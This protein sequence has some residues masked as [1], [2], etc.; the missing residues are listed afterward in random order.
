MSHLLLV[1]D[2]PN[3]LSSLRRAL[4][5][6]PDKIFCGE[7]SVEMYT[8]PADALARAKEKA[9]DLVISDY[10]MPEIDG[11]TFL[12][13]LGK[14]QP[15]IARIIVSGFADLA[16]LIEAI[17]RAQIFRFVSK[18]WDECDL[19]LAISQA[20]AHRELM[21]E[22]ARL[23]DELRAERGKL[24]RAEL[25]LKRLEAENPGLAYVRRSPD[26]GIELDPDELK[27]LDDLDTR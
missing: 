17:N 3:I 1:D 2:E 10:R 12:E 24:S 7:L 11:V 16:A 14:I 21:L 9:F 25:A 22:N 26:G 27:G 20:L 19:Q 6:M 23:A 18:P 5:A 13:A 15:D 8:R 4:H